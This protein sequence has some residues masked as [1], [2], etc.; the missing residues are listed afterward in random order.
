MIYENKLDISDFE[1]DTLVSFPKEAN[2]H[3]ELFN[4]LKSVFLK[5]KVNAPYQ[6]VCDRCAKNIQ[7]PI[8]FEFESEVK[9]GDEIENQDD[10]ILLIDS[11]DYLDLKELVI[12]LL[13]MNMPM[14]TLCADGC[15]GLCPD[16]GTDLNITQCDCQKNKVDPR[17]SVLKK[18]LDK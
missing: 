5:L 2:I 10:D 9:V 15:K 1:T 7:I 13:L 11:S 3:L 6:T 8:E 16:C 4:R 12:N 14:K 18:L 17:L